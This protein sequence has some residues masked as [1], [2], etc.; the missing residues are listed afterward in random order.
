MQATANFHDLIN[1]KKPVSPARSD[2][3]HKRIIFAPACLEIEQ[4]LFHSSVFLSGWFR[5]V[6][7]SAIPAL[8]LGFV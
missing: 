7:G 5:I 8:L 3:E 6:P 2:R 1:E 4:A